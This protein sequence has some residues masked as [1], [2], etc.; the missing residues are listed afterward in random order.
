MRTL[1]IAL[2]LIPSLALAASSRPDRITCEGGP[3]LPVLD[4]LV[5]TAE[6]AVRLRSGYIAEKRSDGSLRL[7]YPTPAGW[8]ESYVAPPEESA[9]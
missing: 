5:R 6:I 9:E 4:G 2:V 8:C 3:D 1:V 7:F